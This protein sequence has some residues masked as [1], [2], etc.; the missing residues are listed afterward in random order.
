MLAGFRH[1]EKRELD[2]GM[3]NGLKHQLNELSPFIELP[4]VGSSVPRNLIV[5]EFYGQVYE[6]WVEDSRGAYGITDELPISGFDRFA[7]C[8]FLRVPFRRIPRIALPD[9]KTLGAVLMRWRRANPDVVMLLRG[10]TREHLIERDQATL[11]VLYGDGHAIEPSLLPSAERAG[12]DFDCV[13]AEWLTLLDFFLLGNCQ[14]EERTRMER[15]AQTNDRLGLG[16]AMAQHYGLP[17]VGLDVTAAIDVALFFALTEFV[18][19]A[20]AGGY[21]TQGVDAGASP[22]LYVF[23]APDRFAF[24][25]DMLSVS[26]IVAAPR[27]ERQAAYFMHTGWGL[28]KNQN[29]RYLLAAIYLDPSSDLGPVPKAQRLFPDPDPFAQFLGG[30]RMLGTSDALAE[31]LALARPVIPMVV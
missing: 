24:A 27:P 7:N 9:R 20:E 11:S 14:G 16:M 10:Q 22:V 6:S 3:A 19:D 17:S 28:A 4:T 25:H 13:M 26:D 15:F 18:F 2:A 31:V 1:I 23:M 5:D 30:A 12:V 29:A 8:G 21:V